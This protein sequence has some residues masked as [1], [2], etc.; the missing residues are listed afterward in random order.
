MMEEIVSHDSE[1]SGVFI[2]Q[3]LE[4]RVLG[5]F[6]D[7]IIEGLFRRPC[8]F[9]YSPSFVV[10]DLYLVSVVHGGVFRNRG[11]YSW[12]RRVVPCRGR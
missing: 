5:R 6:N 8:I 11:V 7:L 1:E 2:R 12:V 9:I 3:L 4:V 10:M